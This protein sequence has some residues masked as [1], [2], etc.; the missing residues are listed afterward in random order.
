MNIS[1]QDGKTARTA[2][3]LRPQQMKYLTQNSS[4][5]LFCGTELHVRS[6]S[7]GFHQVL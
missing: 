1:L 7:N 5:C 2:K 6:I 3:T 4:S